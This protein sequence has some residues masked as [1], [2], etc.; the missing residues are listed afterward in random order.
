MFLLLDAALLTTIIL[1]ADRVPS[2][3]VASHCRSVASQA[4]PVGDPLACLREEQEARAQLVAQ[5]T[6]FPAADQSYCRELT[7]RGGEPTFTELLTCL[8]LRREARRLRE[9]EK[10]TTGSPSASEKP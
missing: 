7:T 1:V 10:E 9:K 2:F 4:T 8:E 5:W 3:D 6:Q